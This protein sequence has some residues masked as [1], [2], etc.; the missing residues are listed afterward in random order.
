MP[1]LSL[2]S[3]PQGMII[4]RHCNGTFDRSL[5]THS[6]FRRTRKSCAV[7]CIR[8]GSAEPEFENFFSPVPD[9]NLLLPLAETEF[10]S[11]RGICHGRRGRP[12][13]FE[14]RASWNRGHS[15]KRATLPVLRNASSIRDLLMKSRRRMQKIPALNTVRARAGSC[16]T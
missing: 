8:L 3:L 11:L 5:S 14:S 2:H 6:A 15:R 10:L 12:C 16:G 13:G 1:G 4:S 9:V 7:Y